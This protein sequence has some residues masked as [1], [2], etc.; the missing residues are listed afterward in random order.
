MSKEEDKKIAIIVSKNSLEDVYAGLIMAN[1]AVMEGIETIMFFTFF[2]LDAITKKS[3]NSLKVGNAQGFISKMPPMAGP[4]PEN[5]ED[6]VTEQIK[7]QFESMDFA[8]VDEFI[9]MISAGGGKIYACKLAADM[10]H[11]SEEDFCD[12]LNGIISVGEMYELTGG[13]QMVFI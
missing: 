12:E 8:P 13:A 1:G 4:I 3:M 6:F 10:F 7:N 11:L 9:E 2:G 5:I